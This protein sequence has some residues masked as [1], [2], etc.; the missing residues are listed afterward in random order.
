MAPPERCKGGASQDQKRLQSQVI[1]RPSKP[2]DGPAAHHLTCI[3]IAREIGQSGPARGSRPCH[4]ADS[5]SGGVAA[6]LD[7][8][9]AAFRGARAHVT[10]TEAGRRALS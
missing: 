9:K 4:G 1:P 8:A 5:P 10:I 6:T 7:E 2:Y 3:K